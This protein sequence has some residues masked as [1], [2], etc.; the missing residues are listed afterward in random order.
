MAFAPAAEADVAT[1]LRAAGAIVLGKLNMDECALGA[2][3]D[4]PHHGAT[5][6]PWRIGHSAGGSSGGA[7]AAVAA[8]VVPMAHGNDVGGS[9]RIPASC[10]GLVGLKPSRGRTS[11][12]PHYGDIF[13]GY[14]V[15]HAL[16]RSVR[17]SAYM[18]DEVAGQDVGAYYA[19]PAQERPFR[20][21]IERDPPRL[22]IAWSASGPD[23]ITPHPDCVKAVEH[24]AKICADLG[25][26]VEQT[27]PRLPEELAAGFGEAFLGAIAI[28][29]ARDADEMAELAGKTLSADLIEPTNWSFIE[30]GRSFS[31]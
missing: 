22:K 11:V 8:G 10:C 28:E 21:E 16:T 1:V 5:N 30:H 7:G 25:H 24:A 27:C 13:S 14:F 4:N 2:A 26:E 6:N 20:D 9:I 23:D 3:T 31:G 15:E 29:T 18:L 12:G 19:A 17:D